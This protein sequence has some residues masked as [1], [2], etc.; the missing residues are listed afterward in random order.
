MQGQHNTLREGAA[1][2]GLIKYLRSRKDGIAHIRD[3]AMRFGSTL[4][5]AEKKLKRAEQY[6]HVEGIGDGRYRLTDD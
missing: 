6:G 5:S 2:R 3:V 1:M 4:V